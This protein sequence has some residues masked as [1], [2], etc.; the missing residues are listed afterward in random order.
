MREGR[1]RTEG[2]R[3]GKYQQYKNLSRKTCREDIGKGEDKDQ[4]QCQVWTTAIPSSPLTQAFKVIW[5]IMHMHIGGCVTFQACHPRDDNTQFTGKGL[6]CSSMHNLPNI[7]PR[8]CGAIG[9]KPRSPKPWVAP[10][11]SHRYCS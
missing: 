2:K 3:K 1:V 6:K 4:H 11:Q 9:T 7:A 8:T 10:M 5:Q